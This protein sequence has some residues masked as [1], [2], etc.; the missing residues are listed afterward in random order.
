LGELFD[1]LVCQEDIANPKP[2][3]EAY[4]LAR[5]RLCGENGK[6]VVIEDSDV[7]VCAAIAANLPVWRVVSFP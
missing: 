4:L 6:C 5:D 3:P 1:L 2:H 7:G